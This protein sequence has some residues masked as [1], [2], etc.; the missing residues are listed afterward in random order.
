MDSPLALID[1]LRVLEL[2]A[3]HRAD[4]L[5]ILIELSDVR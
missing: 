5:V 3:K 2:L 1:E 4:W